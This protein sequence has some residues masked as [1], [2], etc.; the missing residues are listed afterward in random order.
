MPGFTTGEMNVAVHPSRKKN[1]MAGPYLIS[2]LDFY[3]C[4]KESTSPILV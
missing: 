4:K 3:S 1:G 2:W